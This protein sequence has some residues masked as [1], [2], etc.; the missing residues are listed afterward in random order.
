MLGTVAAAGAEYRLA[1]RSLPTR[2]G[3]EDDEA[4]GGEYGKVECEFENFLADAVSGADTATGPTR[5]VLK[6]PS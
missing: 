1:E 2:E 4:C 3:V 6:R 5:Q